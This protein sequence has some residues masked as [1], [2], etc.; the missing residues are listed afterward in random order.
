[1]VKVTLSGSISTRGM[2]AK[3]T[4]ASGGRA[5]WPSVEAGEVEMGGQRV[6]RLAAVGEVGDQRGDAEAVERLQIDIEDGIAVSDEMG[7]GVPAGLAGS[8]GEHDALAGH[9][10]D[11][12]LV[13]RLS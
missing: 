1:M 5:A 10:A 6:E 8:A 4:T 9:G 12:P 3:C 11:P 13:A 7:N 2:A